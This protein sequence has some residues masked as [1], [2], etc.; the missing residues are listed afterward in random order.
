MT[1]T[2]DELERL[3]KIEH[4]ELR[5][6]LSRSAR[7]QALLSDEM[8]KEAFDGVRQG[9][10]TSMSESES[11]ET[12]LDARRL[13]RALRHVESMIRKHVNDGKLAQSELDKMMPK[14]AYLEQHL[15]QRIA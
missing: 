6:A 5:P 11:D 7:A 12:A 3:S 2:E 14:R 4:D 9:L 13:L 15:P 8:L 10:I 1:E